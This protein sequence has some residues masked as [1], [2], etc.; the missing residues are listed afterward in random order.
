MFL[1]LSCLFCVFSPHLAGMNLSPVARLKKTW[2]KV[3]TAKF[4]VLEVRV[5][6][7]LDLEI[8]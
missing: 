2:S 4:D 3:K 1:Q 7:R 5:K 8:R 6:V